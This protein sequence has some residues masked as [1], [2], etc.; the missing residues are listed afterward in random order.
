MT[1]ASS[2]GL[3]TETLLSFQVPEEVIHDRVQRIHQ[4]VLAQSRY[5]RK[6]DFSA[7]HPRDLAWLFGAYDQM[8]YREC[9]EFR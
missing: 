4:D 8:F 1:A 5:L 6:A 9:P 2:R 7:I 3:L